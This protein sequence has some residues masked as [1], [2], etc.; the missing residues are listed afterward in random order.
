MQTVL[1]QSATLDASTVRLG[2]TSY[3]HLKI[4][5]SRRGFGSQAVELKINELM[6]SKFNVLL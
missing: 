1:V 6:F 4:K 2:S 5:G 3:I